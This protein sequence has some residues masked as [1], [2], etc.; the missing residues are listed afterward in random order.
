MRQREGRTRKG[1]EVKGKNKWNGKK[2]VTRVEENMQK[3]YKET[4]KYGKRTRTRKEGKKEEGKL[5]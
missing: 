5:K 3:Q 2:V 4:E 1:E